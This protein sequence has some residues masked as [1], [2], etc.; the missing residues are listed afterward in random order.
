MNEPKPFNDGKIPLNPDTSL[1]LTRMPKKGVS[2][3][4][5]PKFYKMLRQI[6]TSHNEV[7]FTKLNLDNFQLFRNNRSQQIATIK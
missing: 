4:I 5:K 1:N 7:K 6:M 2:N 3:R